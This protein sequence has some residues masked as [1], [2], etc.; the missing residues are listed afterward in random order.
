MNIQTTE[1]RSFV[2]ANKVDILR[3]FDDKPGDQLQTY[4]TGQVD[5]LKKKIKCI[6]FGPPP[7]VKK[8]LGT[9]LESEDS[10][11]GNFEDEEQRNLFA[12]CFM[13]NVSPYLLIKK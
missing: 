2:L 9:I 4:H 3:S 8:Y 6:L 10:D 1:S 11:K 13:E 7:S 5:S 12:R